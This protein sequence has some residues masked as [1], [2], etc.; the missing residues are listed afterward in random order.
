MPEPSGPHV[1]LQI[2]L[3]GRM[4]GE[5]QNLAGSI[6]KNLIESV[7]SSMQPSAKSKYSP[8]PLFEPQSSPQL[9][10]NEPIRIKFG[11]MSNS[12]NAE[13]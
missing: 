10:I 8:M 7:I 12:S 3:S 9:K 1:Q 5:A 2:S 13:Q 6:G 11:G 4:D